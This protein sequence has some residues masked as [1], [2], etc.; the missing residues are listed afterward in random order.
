MS[1]EF[2]QKEVN[3]IV[4]EYDFPKNWAMAS[5]WILGN[6]KGSNLKVIDVAKTSGL[7]D[8]FIIVSAGNPIQAQSM[9]E[10]VAFQAKRLKQ[11]VLSIEGKGGSDWIL[12]DLGDVIVHIFSESVRDIYD[13]D[14]LYADGPI[15]EIPHEYYFSSPEE[16]KEEGGYF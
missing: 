10:E 5:A 14:Q 2:V 9:A 11:T 4:A 15:V 6:L 16:E 13:L 7:A 8:Y 12:I 3:K 1:R